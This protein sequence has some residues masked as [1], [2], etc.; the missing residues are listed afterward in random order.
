MTTPEQILFDLQNPHTFTGLE[1]NR[2]PKLF[3]Q[4]NINICLIFPDQYEIGMS[5]QGIKLLYQ[6]LNDMPG[7]NAERCFLPDPESVSAFRKH[8][9]PL[10]SLE[11]R[12]EVRSFDLLAFSILSEL[13]FT[14]VLAVLDLAQI[15]LLSDDRSSYPIVAAGGISIINPEPLRQ[16]IDFFA[17]GDGEVFFSD[18]IQ[19]LQ[20]SKSGKLDRNQALKKLASIP[21]SYVPA[22]VPLKEEKTFQIPDTNGKTIH[23]R[24]T[25][26]L[27]PHNRGDSAGIVPL[28]QVVFDRFDIEV[29][30]G[31]PNACRF[32]QA[33]NYY[34]PYRYKSG[35]DILDQID[36]SL[37]RT[38]FDT[39]S[40]ASLSTGDH[41]DLPQILAGIDEKLPHCTAFSFPSLRPR[42]LSNEMLKA[43]ARYRRTG[44]TI[45]PE[46][47]SERLRSVIGKE[48]TDEEILKAVDNAIQ[49]KWQKIKMYFMIG[50][51]TE[52]ETDIEAIADLVF[53]VQN[54]AQAHRSKIELTLSFSTF[55]PKPHTPF[56]WAARISVEEA[57][58]RIGLIRSRL[59]MSKRI[60]IDFHS[61][62]K[63]LVETILS[64]GDARTGD[65]I[66][67][68]YKAGE[69]NTAW[70]SFFH[71]EIWMK[72]IEEHK[73]SFVL[74]QLDMESPL[75]WS[76]IQIN[77]PHTILAREY[78]AVL[79]NRPQKACQRKQCSSCGLCLSGHD[80]LPEPPSPSSRALTPQSAKTNT[81]DLSVK[82]RI[83]YEKTGDFRFFPHLSMSK[84]IERII[85]ISALPFRY[86]EGFHPRIKMAMLPPLPVFSQSLCECTELVLYENMSS[87]DIL[88]RLNQVGTPLHFTKVVTVP[89]MAS[90]LMK[91]LCSMS[92]LFTGLTDKSRLDLISAEMEENEHFSETKDGLTLQIGSK[93]DIA[94]RFGK[95]YRILDPERKQ[96]RHLMRSALAFH[97]DLFPPEHR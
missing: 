16:F 61:P 38:G 58:K 45:V 5:H 12:R 67:A 85:R 31:C 52:N 13:N 7:V 97:S 47:G 69:T 56:Q 62:E 76:F 80:Q 25:K 70:D 49:N 54:I 64:R 1:I 82:V 14:N 17:F 75:P 36:T 87:H 20:Q 65:L 9:L 41:P 72:L 91:D 90:S 55:V 29:A 59:R 4:D 81:G 86:S 95:L 57:K 83:F 33:R 39:L 48:V 18:I 22:L 84:Y 43:V 78:S 74:D 37:K 28:G 44:L 66:L 71:P 32:C 50:L 6:L 21:G 60:K 40:L 94:A 88:T 2:S 93:R 27:P 77:Q 26:Q 34:A 3:T 68:A 23:K 92:Y 11:N 35:R 53:K 79:F 8:Q 24:Y 51:P 89:Q 42:T 46:A 15:P 30:R 73:L 96:T 19:I 10:F 63:G